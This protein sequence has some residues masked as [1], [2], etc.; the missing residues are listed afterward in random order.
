[1]A[2]EEENDESFG[3]FTFASFSSQPIP[4]SSNDTNPVDDDN[5]GDFVNHSNHQINGELSKPFNSFG[6]SPDPTKKHVNGNN[7]VALQAEVAK[8]PK[9]VISLSIF[10]EEEEE[11]QG[12]PASANVFSNTSNGRAV[13]RGSVSNGKLNL[14]EEEDEHEDGWEF[15]STEWKTGTKSQ[16]VK[17][18]VPKHDNGALDVGTMS[19]SS[20]GISDKV[21][22]WHLEF[23]FSPRSTSQNHISPQPSL[24]SESN[25][26]GTGFAM[27]NRN[28]GKLS[29]G[30]GSNQNLEAS[31]KAD[32]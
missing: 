28:F 19:N 10:D 8:K 16:D 21:G 2:E 31:K 15:K 26:V 7:G 12:E 20:N 6:V 5:W 27:F 32:I 18:E 11:E 14:H 29:L 4:S 1:M 25:D 13:K 3:D 9:G 22:G 24:K 23:E 17:V 30:S